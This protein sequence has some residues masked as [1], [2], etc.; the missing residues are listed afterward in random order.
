VLDTDQ[1]K[2]V[3]LRYLG[4]KVESG[5]WPR[6]DAMVRKLRPLSLSVGFAATLTSTIA[7]S[8]LPSEGQEGQGN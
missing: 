3:V 2:A 1:I 5:R 7:R 6:R 4:Q 8:Q